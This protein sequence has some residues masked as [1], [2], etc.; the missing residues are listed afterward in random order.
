[1][2]NQTHLKIAFKRCP[3][4]PKSNTFFF[5]SEGFHEC[6]LSPLSM[7]MKSERLYVEQIGELHKILLTSLYFTTKVEIMS[8]FVSKKEKMK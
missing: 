3:A 4:E 8:F 2:H 5:S 6:R 7:V 1:M